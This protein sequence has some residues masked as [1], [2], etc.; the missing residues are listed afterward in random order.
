MADWAVV[1]VFALG[2]N[3]WTQE[4]GRGA[5]AMLEDL[6]ISCMVDFDANVDK[7]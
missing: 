1:V 6:V 5:S 3:E 7:D 4:L 2:P